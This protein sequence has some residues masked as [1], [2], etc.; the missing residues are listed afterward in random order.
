MTS[1][2]LI[3]SIL[4]IV[5]SALLNHV[6]ASGTEN[7]QVLDFNGMEVRDLVSV[8]ETTIKS[9][10]Y[11]TTEVTTDN[12]V[13]FTTKD[14]LKRL[15]RTLISVAGLIAACL[16]ICCLP[17]CY[18]NMRSTCEEQKSGTRYGMRIEV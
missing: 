17:W 11:E 8:Q 18:A 4:I 14:D 1:T 12:H 7:S 5:I 9:I 13:S 10:K 15:E 6:M 3:Y 16:F 2:K